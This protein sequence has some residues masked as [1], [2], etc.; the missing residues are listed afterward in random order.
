[1][2]AQQ[3]AHP[4]IERHH[5]WPPWRFDVPDLEIGLR[6]PQLHTS[7]RC[8]FSALSEWWRQSQSIVPLLDFTTKSFREACSLVENRMSFRCILIGK[9]AYSWIRQVAL[10]P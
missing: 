8:K 7:P 10:F 5:S 6:L 1:M 3:V 4:K 2:E 9:I